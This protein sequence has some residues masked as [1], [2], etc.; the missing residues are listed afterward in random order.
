MSTELIMPALSP[1]MEV[2][3]LARWLVAEGDAV[4]AGDLLAEIETDKATM[5]V[6]AVDD[7]TL[8]RIVVPEGTEGVAV[9]AVIA[10][11][12]AL[13]AAP[14]TPL[15]AAVSKAVSPVPPIVEKP[16]ARAGKTSPLARRIAIARDID[17]D[18]LNGSGPGGKIV[19]M[20]LGLPDI[21][22]AR[23]AP[24][25]VAPAMAYGP[26]P[27][28]PHEVIEL[29]GMRRTIARRL[30]EA[31]RTVPHFYLTVDCS[32]DELL[33]LRGELNA[34]PANG[35]VKLSV[36]DFLIK[37]LALALVMVP[38]ANVQFAEDRMYR[39]GR[40]DIAM[41]VAVEGGLL[42][43]VIVDAAE[44][45]LSTIARETKVLVALARDGKLKPE[46]Y[47]GGTA[48]ISNLGMFGVKTIVPVI[49]SPQGMI[50]GIGAGEKRPCV[51]DDQL[52]IATMM[53]AT[54]SF[55]HRAIDGAVGAEFMRAFKQ[56]VENPLGILV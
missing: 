51:I 55:D 5:E 26:P 14:A 39:F 23:I 7:G 15:A 24:P 6:E 31:K 8:A 25:T 27:G 44:K 30:A 32:L 54:G 48:S 35:D 41:A 21:A 12:G 37:A 34:G 16:V 22:P 9:G 33:A 47:Q 1:T 13:G 53:S 52:A 19:K 17:L 28:I 42:T 49:N 45:R 20:D 43:P 56:L 11:M 36:N 38:D 18:R 4:K 2:G 10:L 29:S 46:Q 40:A 50:L 3:K